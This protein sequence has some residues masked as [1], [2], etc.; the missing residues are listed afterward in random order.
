M[1][2]SFSCFFFF[3]SGIGLDYFIYQSPLFP[4]VINK[5]LLL[6]LVPYQTYFPSFK[7]NFSE[8][9]I[10]TTSLPQDYLNL[11][12]S[13][14]SHIPQL[15]RICQDLHHIQPHF[16]TVYLWL[17][18]SLSYWKALLSYLLEYSTILVF[19]LGLSIAFI[20]SL[21]CS[22]CFVNLFPWIQPFL[23]RNI[24][25][26]ISSRLIAIII[27]NDDTQLFTSN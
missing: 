17:L 4:L 26:L 9:C 19:F 12:W 8:N 1:G 23:S 22:S 20:I 24:F 16:T 18:I 5:T 13:G 14:F 11:K 6:A 21:V 15:K 7:L 3:N 25:L 2:E 27:L 10:F